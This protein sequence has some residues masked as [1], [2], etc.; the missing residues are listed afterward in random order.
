ML[1]LIV[2]LRPSW[3][4][5]VCSVT[6]VFL[7]LGAAGV[8]AAEIPRGP[9]D[10]LWESHMLAGISAIYEDG[11]RSEYVPHASFEEAD[12]K[13]GTVWPT[14]QG[15]RVQDFRETKLGGLLRRGGWRIEGGLLVRVPD[16]VSTVELYGKSVWR[17]PPSLVRFGK[18]PPRAADHSYLLWRPQAGAV[19]IVVKKWTIPADQVPYDYYLRGQMEY[20]PTRRVAI[21]RVTGAEDRRVLLEDLVGVSQLKMP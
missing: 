2:N 9:L 18:A 6:W 21:V 1:R 19:A 14:K 17:V 12:G 10:A 8:H 7:G 3:P 15:I 20:N 11:K 13:P 16:G 4:S 5:C